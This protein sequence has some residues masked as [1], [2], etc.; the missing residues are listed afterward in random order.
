MANLYKIRT[1]TCLGCGVCFQVR[2]P[3]AKVSYCSLPC[4]RASKRPNRLSGDVVPCSQCDTKFYRAAS[5]Q[6]KNNLC[7]KECFNKWHARRKLHYVCKTCAKPFT[8]S[9]SRIKANSPKYCSVRCS[10]ICPEWKRAAAIQGNLVQSRNKALNKLEL[11]GE[12]ILKAL[13]LRFNSQHLLFD[14]FLVDTFLPNENVVIQWDGDYWH[15]HPTKIKGGIPD[16]RQKKRMSLDK[17]Q[18]AYM[19]KR[20][21]KILR[22]WES[23]VINQKEKVIAAITTSV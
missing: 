7:S 12:E 22:F 6:S 23:E 17:S 21:V 11:A 19:K 4:Y 1:G 20:G 5:S 2:R 15:G 3:A 8:W 16:H 9:P 13:G 18:D 10:S 14:K